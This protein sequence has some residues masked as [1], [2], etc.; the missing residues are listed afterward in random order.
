MLL[1]NVI[2]FAF[3]A[4]Y[5]VKVLRTPTKDEGDFPAGA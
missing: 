1:A 2:V 4:F 5:F 3:T